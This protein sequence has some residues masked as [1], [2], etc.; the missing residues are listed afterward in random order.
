MPKRR[1]TWPGHTSEPDGGLAPMPQMS[2]LWIPGLFLLPWQAGYTEAVLFNSHRFLG[3]AWQLLCVAAAFSAVR[4]PLPLS[5]GSR[6][7]PR[8]D[9]GAQTKT[10]GVGSRAPLRSPGWRR[11][12]S[13]TCRELSFTFNELV[14]H[15]AVWVEF[16]CAKLKLCNGC[17][18]LSSTGK[19]KQSMKSGQK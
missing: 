7:P 15:P 9:G 14:S 18:I 3:P 13:R 4:Q 11:P 19:E 16:N 17:R 5:A 8:V 6:G 1:T 2:V 10:A 12:G